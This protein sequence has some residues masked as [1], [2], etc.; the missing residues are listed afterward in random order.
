MSSARKRTAMFI[1]HKLPNFAFICQNKYPLRLGI[2][3]AEEIRLS[4]A[5]V[6]IADAVGLTL[7]NG[8]PAWSRGYPIVIAAMHCDDSLVGTIVSLIGDGLDH[9]RHTH[10]EICCL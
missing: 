1:G 4:A 5:S 3:A 8:M 10:A 6:T 9:C 2:Y 7:P